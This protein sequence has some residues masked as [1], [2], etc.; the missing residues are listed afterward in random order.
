MS[1]DNSSSR[2][3]AAILFA[4]IVGYTTLMQQ[5]EGKAMSILTRFQEVTA[6]KVKES[7]GEIIKSYGDGSLII[8]DSTVDA[9]QCAHDM[10]IAFRQGIKVP[11]RI[12]IHVGEFIKKD[13]DIFGNGVNIAARIES[14]GV[15]GGVLMTSY[16]QKRIKNQENLQT[17]SLG[18]YDLKNVEEAIE[19]YALTNEGLVVPDKNKLAGR[20]RKGISKNLVLTGVVAAIALVI[21]ALWIKNMSNSE[22][23]ISD[24]ALVQELG[25]KSLAVLPFTNMSSGEEN[26]Y[27]CDG[28]HDDLLTHLSQRASMKVISRTSVLRYRDTELPIPEIAGALGVSHI[29][30]GSFRRVDN[31]IRIN[32]QL[33]DAVTDSHVWSEIYDQELNTENVF[34]FQTEVTKK[35]AAA[36]DANLSASQLG[37][38]D[39]KPT[40]NLE[41][42]EAYLKGRQIMVKR[43]T[44]SLLAAKQHF[45]KAISLDPNFS[46]ALIQLGTVHHLM[47]SYSD[48]D[49]SENR[50]KSLEY[51]NRGLKIN[52]NMAEAY[53]L[54]AIIHENEKEHEK[55]KTAFEKAIQLNPNQAI[56]YHWYALFARDVER[57][58]EKAKSLLEQ[59]RELDPLSPS[60]NYALGRLLFGSREFEK[61]KHFLKKT[62]ELEPSYPST[63]LVLPLLYTAQNRLDS[64]AMLAYQNLRINGN[65]GIYFE[66]SMYP[67][68]YLGMDEELLAERAIFKPQNRQDSIIRYRSSLRSLIHI[69]KDLKKAHLFVKENDFISRLEILFSMKEWKQYIQLYEELNPKVLAKEYE[70]DPTGISPN[71][72]YFVF[73]NYLFAL[74]M[75]GRTVEYEDL[76]RHYNHQVYTDE[77]ELNWASLIWKDYVLMRQACTSENTSEAIELLKKIRKNGGFGWIWRRFDQDPIFDILVADKDYIRIMEDWNQLIEDQRATVRSSL[78]V[79]D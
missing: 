27:F 60:V 10:Q 72:N 30:E 73:Q 61:G 8:F 77:S 12:G 68:Y 52:P 49:V 1:T 79:S 65:K 33:I 70:F 32:V 53:A 14:M 28:M 75:D 31:Q 21:L 29:L 76:W 48:G 4:D 18:F 9:V 54:K 41:A 64:A 67:L 59:A 17:Q 46:Q 20:K 43:N 13:R 45:E 42:Y 58:R 35:I 15:S 50:S 36:L 25:P 47:I 2:K 62:K 51:L 24:A 55:A 56:T 7:R 11:L 63:Y 39:E 6:D 44:P 57:D 74:K 34:R 26:Q 71:W 66:H 40:A 16:V 23:E 69:K 78:V 5:G 38:V 3:L 22:K 19:V 37:A